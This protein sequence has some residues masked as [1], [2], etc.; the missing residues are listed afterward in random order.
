MSNVLL[1]TFL[2]A[3]SGQAGGA[4]LSLPL[5]LAQAESDGTTGNEGGGS[6]LT[7]FVDTQLSPTSEYLQHLTGME[8]V[9]AVGLM[10]AGLVFLLLG[11]KVFK[12]WVVIDA[13]FMGWLL[14]DHL[15]GLAHGGEGSMPLY[16]AIAG[17]LLMMIL[18]WPLMKWA[19]SVMGALAG[20]QLGYSAWL[21]ITA[22]A[23]HQDVA[24][25]AW[26][27]AL[28]GMITLGLLAFVMLR[29]VVIISTSFQGSMM[30]ISGTLGIVMRY[31]PFRAKLQP[32]LTGTIHVMPLLIVLTAVIGLA[33]QMT[34]SKP[35]KKE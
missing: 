12:F 2:P 30:F 26:A 27:G 25:H 1:N 7:R 33:V 20:G 15:G 21:Y 9:M 34:E 32:A 3:L 16:G 17:A 11:W 31:E 6:L 8:T 14:G 5:M 18:S 24:Q 13:G 10:A 19:V 23:G 28:L 4:C 22:V 35:K 29:Y